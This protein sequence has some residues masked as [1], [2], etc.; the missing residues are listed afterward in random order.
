MSQTAHFLPTIS[1]ALTNL[2]KSEIKSST[3]RRK[4][5]NLAHTPS[6][7]VPSSEFSTQ[8]SATVGNSLHAQLWM[9]G[10]DGINERTAK[11]Q[12][13]CVLDK[14]LLLP[15]DSGDAQNRTITQGQYTQPDQDNCTGTTL[16]AESNDERLFHQEDVLGN[17]RFPGSVSTDTAHTD[18]AFNTDDE[19]L[20][21][22]D[23]QESTSTSFCTPS[24]NVN[25]QSPATKSNSS[26]LT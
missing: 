26:D 23:F 22:V 10:Q 6:M 18:L 7:E 3:L 17:S 15:V 25:Q 13:F 9:L 19:E 1:R 20:M 11:L 2:A 12:S 5:L 4:L 24:E 16:Y 21:F 14:D 8:E